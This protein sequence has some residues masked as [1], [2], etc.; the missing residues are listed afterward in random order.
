MQHVMAFSVALS[1]RVRSA[2]EEWINGPGSLEPVATGRLEPNSGI[3]CQIES[4]LIH[5]M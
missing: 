1:G 5:L 3:T 4:V 2:P